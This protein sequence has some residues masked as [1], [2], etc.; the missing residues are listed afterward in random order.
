MSTPINIIFNGKTILN[1]VETCQITVSGYCISLNLTISDMSLWEE[2]NI[3]DLHGSLCLSVLI[4]DKTYQFLAE[5]KERNI[6]IK[7]ESFTIWGRSEQALLDKKFSETYTDTETSSHIWQSACKASDIIDYVRGDIDVSLEIDD[8]SVYQDTFSVSDK[9]GLDILAQLADEIGAVLIPDTEGG[10]I[11]REYKT[12]GQ[13]VIKYTELD[14]IITVSESLES[15][16]GLNA[17]TVYGYTDPEVAKEDPAGDDVGGDSVSQSIS[18]SGENQLDVGQWGLVN[19]YYYHSADADILDYSDGL[20][21]YVGEFQET[22]TESVDLKW[23][24]GNT[25]YANI[26]GKNEVTGNVNIPFET[27]TVS[28]TIKYKQYKFLGVAKGDYKILFYFNDKS[29]D[30]E[31]SFTVDNP[32][33]YDIPVDPDDPDNPVDPDIPEEEITPEL[34]QLCDSLVVEQIE[35]E[36]IPGQILTIAFYNPAGLPVTLTG[37]VWSEGNK[38]KQVTET[39]PSYPVKSMITAGVLWTLG[40]KYVT[41]EQE[42]II[43][44]TEYTI[45]KYQINAT[46]WNKNLTLSFKADGC[47]EKTVSYI[48]KS[49]ISIDVETVD[50]EIIQVNSEDVDIIPAT[51]AYI[52]TIDGDIIQVTP[53]SPD[54]TKV[55]LSAVLEQKSDYYI[56]IKHKIRVYFYHPDNSQINASAIYGT[57]TGINTGTE[58]ITES[59]TLEWGV[60]NTSKPN[61]NGI[62]LQTGNSAIAKKIKSVIYNVKYYD[63]EYLYN[64]EIDDTITFYYADKSAETDINISLVTIPEAV[65]DDNGDTISLLSPTFTPEGGTYTAKQ[66]IKITDNN[67]KTSVYYSKG[68]TEYLYVGTWV[69]ISE[70]TTL[71]AYSKD[72]EGNK[73]ET[74]T[75]DYEITGKVSS[76]VFSI[77]PGTYSESQSVTLSCDTAGATIRYTFSEFEGV[78]ENSPEYT[79]AFE[80]TSGSVKIQAKAFLEGWLASDVLFGTFTITTE[81]VFQCDTPI[82]SKAGGAYADSFSLS[83]TCGTTDALIYYT[84]DSSEPSESDTLYSVTIVISESCIIK[85]IAYKDGWSPSEITS[86]D[87]ALPE[88][89]SEEPDATSYLSADLENKD[90]YLINTQ[91]IIRAYYYNAD[92]TDITAVCINGTVTENIQKIEDITETVQLNWGVGNTTKPDLYGK[93]AIQGD[94]DIPVAYQEVIYQTRY[95]LFSYTHNIPGPDVVS[96]YFVDKSKQSD[97]SISLIGKIDNPVFDPPGGAYDDDVHIHITCAT[98][99]AVIHYTTDGSEPDDTSTIL[100][101]SYLYLDIDKNTTVKAITYKELYEKSDIIEQVYQIGIQEPEIDAPSYLSVSG[102]SAVSSGDVGYVKV[103]WYHADNMPIV[104]YSTGDV[105]YDSDMTESITE[106][107]NLTWGVGNTSKPDLNGQ[108]AVNGD[109]AL[110]FE[111]KEVTYTTKYKKYAISAEADGDYDILFYYSDK[112][113]EASHSFSVSTQTVA[114]PEFTPTPDDFVSGSVV[115]SC[116]TENAVIHYTTNGD[117]PDENSTIYS[118]PIVISAN[119]TIKAIAIR[120]FWNN[121]SIAS[122]QFLTTGSVILQ[123]YNSVT[124]ANEVSVEVFIDGKLTSEGFT[125]AEGRILLSN[126]SIGEHTILLK[127]SGFYDSNMDDLSNDTFTV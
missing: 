76:P 25:S 8:F 105:A 117:D 77:S 98:V 46:Y 103:Y 119:T 64:T 40:S 125:D 94:I 86:A 54:T 63:F 2:F 9:S 74:T 53:A 33:P 48:V 66:Y 21:Q 109:T 1:S 10:L 113:K 23:G 67:Q 42:V 108:T 96:F 15:A 22:V 65:I 28:Y 12:G 85:A 84:T 124:L 43:Y 121:S 107:V 91:H 116:E 88:P 89:E 61:T 37:G 51:P 35:T 114:T 44:N 49:D 38:T 79:E 56:G 26:Y 71:S 59:V 52:E 34:P 126:L 3:K 18:A 41:T 58:S 4:G 55:F 90:E 32:D 20:V 122:G 115:I 17:V 30:T 69:E 47:K 45:Y 11:I 39:E 14:D 50:G 27:K 81:P 127:K 95:Q 87:Y 13:A 5:E 102:D 16:S 83:I 75:A 92:Y 24:V 29:A 111:T 70:D 99:N 60:G 80:V 112:S 62:T 78:N 120:E 97:V 82:F 36:A 57:I 6:D 72:S 31:F 73:S 68:D 123:I 19:V 110:A 93:T 118:V 101:L 106:E 104:W 100:Q 7:Q